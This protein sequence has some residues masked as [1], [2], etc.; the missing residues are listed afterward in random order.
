MN[1]VLPSLHGGSLKV[2]LNAVPLSH[3]VFLHRLSRGT[4]EDNSSEPT[5]PEFVK[6]LLNTDIAVDDEHWQPISLRCR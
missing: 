4:V 2:T 1:R 6:F 5:F 3:T